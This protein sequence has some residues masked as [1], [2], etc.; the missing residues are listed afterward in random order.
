MGLLRGPSCDLCYV[1]SSQ[2]SSGV[3]SDQTGRGHSLGNTDDIPGDKQPALERLEQWDNGNGNS[4]ENNARCCP[5][6]EELLI[7]VLTGACL[8]GEQLC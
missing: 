3:G 5:G 1:K 6:K 2:P 4:A 7:A 8:P